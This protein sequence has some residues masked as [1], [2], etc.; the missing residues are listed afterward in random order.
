MPVKR[1]KEEDMINRRFITLSHMRPWHGIQDYTRFGIL[2]SQNS[3]FQVQIIAENLNIP[4]AVDISEDGRLFFTERGGNLR[5]IENGTLNPVPVYTFGPPF[6]STGEGGLMG[7]ALDRD[8]LSN[9]YIYLMY[10]YEENGGLYNRVVRMRVEGNTASGEEVLLDRIPAG[11]FH[12][13]GRIKIGPDGYLYITAGDAG[14]RYLAQDINSPAGK[15]LRIGTDG[16]IPPDN[17][18]P[19]SPVYALGLRNPQGLAWN[20]RNMLYAS[21]HGEAANDEINLIQPGGNYGWPPVTGDGEIQVNDFIGPAVQSGNETWAP[22]GMA[23]VADGP[24]MGQLLVSALRGSALLAVTFDEA[25]TQAV[26][27]ERLLQG[28][29]GRLREA[30]RAGDGSIY[31]TTSNLDGRGLPDPGDDRILRLVPRT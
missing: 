20:D 21:E 30:Y 3:S 4:W 22:A 1:M 9:G 12:N 19:G 18:F 24:R 23:F 17:P 11:Q 2:N 26:Q 25:G 16:S 31:L 29:Y 13:G 6:V 7:L 27:V 15:I 10:T 8:F 5:V 14:N 28:S